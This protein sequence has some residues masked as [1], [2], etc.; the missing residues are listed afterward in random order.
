MSMIAAHY[1]GNMDN[2]QLVTVVGADR[3]IL[4]RSRGIKFGRSTSRVTPINEVD[5]GATLT[6]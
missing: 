2:M 1:T 5:Q 6:A 4:P 3:S